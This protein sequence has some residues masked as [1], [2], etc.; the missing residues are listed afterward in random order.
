MGLR[1]ITFEP[2]DEPGL[3]RAEGEPVSP[4]L[5]QRNEELPAA[6]NSLFVQFVPGAST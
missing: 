2:V 4:R 5:L 3:G 1:R 6:I